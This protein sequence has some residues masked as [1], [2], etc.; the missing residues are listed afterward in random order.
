MRDCI[1]MGPCAKKDGRILHVAGVKPN[2]SAKISAL[3]RGTM[4]SSAFIDL[5]LPTV[6]LIIMVRTNSV[7]SP[8]K[9]IRCA[10]LSDMG[11]AHAIRF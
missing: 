2:A 10:Q 5:H 7:L 3:A 6:S 1:V 9:T 8:D 11:H 4:I